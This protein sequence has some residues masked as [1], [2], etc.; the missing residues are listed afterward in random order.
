MSEFSERT[1]EEREA[2]RREREARRAARQGES[3]PPPVAPQPPVAPPPPFVRPPEEPAAGETEDWER[4]EEEDVD[5]EAPSGT[6]V[7]YRTPPAAEKTGGDERPKR[8]KDRHHSNALRLLTLLAFAGVIALVWF[9]VE[10]WQPFHGSAGAEVTITIPPHS[11]ESAVASELQREHVI[12]STFF[13]GVR[14]ALSGDGSNLKSGTYRLH[15]NTTYS[16]V[17]AVLTKG[18]PPIKTTEL[19]FTEGKTRGQIDALLRSQ[20]VKGSYLAATRRSPLLDRRR[21]GA[22]RG[23]PSLEGFL[24]PSTYNLREPIS[25][26]ALVADQLQAFKA[27]FARVNLGYARSKHLTPYDVLIIASI[28][29]TEA[30]IAHDRPLV[31]SVIY[32]RLKDQLPLGMD[33]T[34]RYAVDNYRTPLTASQLA[35]RSPY[36]T[37]VHKGLP[38]TPIG[39]PGLAAIQA[40]ANPAPTG[41]LYFVVKPCGNGSSA[42]SSKYQQF[43]ADSSRYQSARAKRGGR[44]PVHC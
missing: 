23:T 17:L 31:A 44:S 25:V 7:V 16:S 15:R 21:Y 22:P 33:S 36:N 34:T 29:E 18:P 40:A 19:T 20:G 30:A 28:V 35:T 6:R 3:V 14:A 1:A 2:A 39:N 26:S 10:L 43:L 4:E 5:F 32:N 24:F 12:S 37:R 41:F 42:F 11:S 8:R 38:P 13:F 27:N 9:A